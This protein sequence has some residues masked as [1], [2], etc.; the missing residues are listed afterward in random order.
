[1]PEE[2]MLSLTISL[3]DQAFRIRVAPDEQERYLR[4]AKLANRALREVSGVGV[5]GGGRALA[6]ALFQMAVE[7]DDAH[8]ALREVQHNQKRLNDLILRID[9]ALGAEAKKS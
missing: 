7:L 3:G 4:I 6:M 1:M 2:N 5:V 8:D 9:R